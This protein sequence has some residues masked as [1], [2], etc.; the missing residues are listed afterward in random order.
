MAECTD[1]TGGDSRSFFLYLDDVGEEVEIEASL[2]VG[3]SVRTMTKPK[4]T[5]G[6]KRKRDGEPAEG[7]T[8]QRKSKRKVLTKEKAQ[9]MLS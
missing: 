8:T 6:R 3:G 1:C 2:S 5:K 7:G 9:V 4:G